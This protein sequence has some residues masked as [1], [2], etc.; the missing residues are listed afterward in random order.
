MNIL[1]YLV[2]VLLKYHEFQYPFQCGSICNKTNLSIEFGSQKGSH[3]K[4]RDGNCKDQ[5]ESLTLMDR[6]K[7][8]QVQ[9]RTYSFSLIK[10][11]T[12]YR[13]YN[14]IE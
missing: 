11:S 5:K 7:G 6:E 13:Y 12:E 3:P 1:R 10:V 8:Y 14:K 2:R 9:E 4:G